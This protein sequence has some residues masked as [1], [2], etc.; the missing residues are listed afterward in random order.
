MSTA[1]A[2]PNSDVTYTWSDNAATDYTRVDDGVRDPTNAA[3]GGDGQ[4]CIA[5][6]AD[7]S[8]IATF[9]CTQPSISGT[10]T[11]V[12][13]KV[14]AGTGGPTISTDIGAY[15]GGSTRT[16]SSH[17]ISSATWYT[18]TYSGLSIA[19]GSFYPCRINI[20]PGGINKGDQLS[21][22]GCYLEITYSGGTAVV[23]PDPVVLQLGV[24]A[25]SLKDVITPSPVPIQLSTVLAGLSNPVSPSP[26]GLELSVIEPQLIEQMSGSPV[27]LQLDVVEGDIT[28]VQQVLTADPVVLEL[29]VPTPSL[30]T[31]VRP[32]PV[33]L[34]L[35]AGIPVAPSTNVTP[36]PVPLQ[37]SVPTGSVAQSI[38]PAPVTLQL[39]VIT[40]TTDPQAA[41]RTGIRVRPTYETRLSV[42]PTYR[43]GIRTFPG[44]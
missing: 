38:S 6:D 10:V 16:A 20:T 34:E 19:A 36:D 33:V 5:G 29:S 2:D 40:P 11:Q 37:L 30:K 13:V 7:D 1:Y 15:F 8:E 12:K 24:V 35:S 4:N 44:G 22:S 17:S 18:T 42:K 23:I 25:A 3:S 39:S 32:S 27:V 43:T 31:Q 28:G 14:F 21:V 26:V 9:G 41:V